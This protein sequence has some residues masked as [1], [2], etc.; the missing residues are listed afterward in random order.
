[1]TRGHT[2]SHA[3]Q[4]S[5]FF[6]R[7]VL[8]DRSSAN[9]RMAMR[10]RL[11][12]FRRFHWPGSLWTTAATLLKMRWCRKAWQNRCSEVGS[13]QEGPNVDS[14]HAATY[15]EKSRKDRENAK[16]KR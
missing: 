3:V 10:V 2:G 1:M 5:H 8:V 15:H 9:R 4:V 11:T 14:L 6:L 16:P 13:R 7:G 12:S